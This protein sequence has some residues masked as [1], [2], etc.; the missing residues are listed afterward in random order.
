MLSHFRSI[1][2]I[3]FPADFQLADY[4]Q[5][6]PKGR[7]NVELSV[8]ATQKEAKCKR[9]RQLQDAGF[10]NKPRRQRRSCGAAGTLNRK[11]MH[12]IVLEG[13]NSSTKSTHKIDSCVVDHF[14]HIVRLKLRRRA[15]LMEPAGASSFFKKSGA[16]FSSCTYMAEWP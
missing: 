11:A 10:A 8:Q 5:I 12:A 2:F 4:D 7:R 1:F 3:F 14:S 13:V 6:V 16:A 15:W 9:S